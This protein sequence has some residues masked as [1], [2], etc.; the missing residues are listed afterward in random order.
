MKKLLVSLIVMAT[1]LTACGPKEEG[2]TIEKPDLKVADGHFT[3]E[4]LHQMGKVTD[5]Q[6]SP[7]GTQILYGVTYT[8]I[9][10]N[11]GVRN[12]FIM[13]IDGSDNHQITHFAKSASNAR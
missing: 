7:D 8:S 6:V 4:V 9:E 3:A 13:N 5:I 11:K 2:Q 12:L 10:Q 1:T